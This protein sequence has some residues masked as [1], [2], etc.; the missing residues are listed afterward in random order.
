[1]HDYTKNEIVAGAF[2]VLGLA[3]LGYLS[4][5]IGGLTLL[6]PEAVPGAGSVLERRRSQGARAR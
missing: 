1:M 6:Q 3:V 4:I 2:V 5:S